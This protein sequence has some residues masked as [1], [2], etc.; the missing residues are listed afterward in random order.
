MQNATRLPAGRAG[1]MLLARAISATTESTPS[2]QSMNLGGTRN[3]PFPYCDADKRKRITI[4]DGGCW[5]Y[6]YHWKL[7]HK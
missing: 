3:I 5:L 2:V 7:Q 4:A 1:F 6:K